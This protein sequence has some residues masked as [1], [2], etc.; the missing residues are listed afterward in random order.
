MWLSILK[1]RSVLALKIWPWLT[2]LSYDIII[3]WLSNFYLDCIGYSFNT[4]NI[5][6]TSSICLLYRLGTR[7][8]VQ[9]VLDQASLQVSARLGHFQ[10]PT[11]ICGNIYFW[12][13]RLLCSFY[14]RNSGGLPNTIDLGSCTGTTSCYRYFANSVWISQKV[15]LF[16]ASRNKSQNKMN[17]PVFKHKI[18]NVI[19]F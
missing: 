13:S 14:S 19:Y 6:G 8:M 12:R 17:D 16:Q 15:L 2:E 11:Y 9:F 4:T 7:T 1:L 18:S 3:I 10:K 5:S